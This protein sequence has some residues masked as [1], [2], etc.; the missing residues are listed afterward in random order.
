MRIGKIGEW[1][2][3]NTCAYSGI[4]LV[5]IVIQYNHMIFIFVLFLF[6]IIRFENVLY[7]G[8]EKSTIKSMHIEKPLCFIITTC[9]VAFVIAPERVFFFTWSFFS[10]LSSQINSTDWCFFY[11]SV[12]MW[13]CECT[14]IEY[15]I[16][17]HQ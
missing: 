9:T 15:H 11:A 8:H 17:F 12:W 6:I 10:S 14:N 5:N 2:L 16:L 3:N 1:D 4:S 13:I 7:D